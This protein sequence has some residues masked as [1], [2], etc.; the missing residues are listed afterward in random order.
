ML[1]WT[2]HEKNDEYSQ[3]FKKKSK[4]WWVLKQKNQFQTSNSNKAF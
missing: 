2:K 1:E 4:N 3:N